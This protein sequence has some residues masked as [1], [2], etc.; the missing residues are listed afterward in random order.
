MPKIADVVGRPQVH[1]DDPVALAQE[2]ALTNQEKRVALASWER[3]A[4]HLEIADDE[5]MAPNPRQDA[6]QATM[7]EQIRHAAE[8]VQAEPK[9]VPRIDKSAIDPDRHVRIPV[10]SDPSAT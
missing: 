2:P 3:D 5:G 8:I 1:F 4:E 10:K 9:P 7:R 6:E